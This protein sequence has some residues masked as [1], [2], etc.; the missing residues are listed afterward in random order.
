MAE[1]VPSS[2]PKKTATKPAKPSS[3]KIPDDLERIEGIGPK[4]AAALQAAGITT[5]GQLAKTKAAKLEKT[6]L[7]AGLRKPAS[8]ATWAEQA[9]LL[10]SGDEAGFVTLTTDLTAGRKKSR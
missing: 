4:F 5:F 6:L 8:L 2:K 9:V 10:A 7:E 3:R 1:V